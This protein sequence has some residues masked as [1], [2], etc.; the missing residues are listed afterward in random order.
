MLSM[1]NVESNFRCTDHDGVRVRAM[2]NGAA[3]QGIIE[4]R[5][6]F[7]MVPQGRLKLRYINS[8]GK[9]IAYKRDNVAEARPSDYRIFS[10]DE[11]QVLE[12]VL[13]RALT[14]VETVE[15]SRRLLI[16]RHTRVHLDDVAGLGR[17][18]ELETVVGE[19]EDEDAQKEHAELVAL[20]G[21]ETCERVAV[22]YV[23]LLSRDRRER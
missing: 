2:A 18:V 8:H 16:H 6:V 22:A 12:E 14:V 1:R 17:F 5:D 23:D 4:Q 21:L 11:P 19:I 10:T 15:K 7:F 13:G 3:D 9:L 20:L